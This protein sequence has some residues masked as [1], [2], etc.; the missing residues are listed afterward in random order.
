MSGSPPAQYTH[1]LRFPV[2]TTPRPNSGAV[3]RTLSACMYDWDSMVTS[4]GDR[5]LG[6]SAGEPSG[7]DYILG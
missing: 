7:E 3:S 5:D 4:S 1:S 2:S 6:L